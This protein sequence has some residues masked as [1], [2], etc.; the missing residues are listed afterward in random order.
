MEKTSQQQK[1]QDEQSLNI[2]Q[3][4]SLGP[5]ILEIRPKQQ[6]VLFEHRH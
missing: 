2:I 5:E 1:S 4:Q 3:K 6:N